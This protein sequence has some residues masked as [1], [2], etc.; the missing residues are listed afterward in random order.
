MTVFVIALALDALGV[1]TSIL[2]TVIPLLLAAFGLAQGQAL[3][4]G[5][6]NVVVNIL[7]SHDVREYFA[8]G[9]LLVHDGVRGA[10]CQIGSVYTIMTT[11]EGSL[12][13]PHSLLLVT[14]VRA[15]QRPGGTQRPEEA[16]VAS[17]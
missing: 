2:V 10:I 3:G 13:I 9:Q 1:N 15:G 7:A 8:I 5:A 16:E 14:E 11:D 4:L 12:L 17:T 6:R